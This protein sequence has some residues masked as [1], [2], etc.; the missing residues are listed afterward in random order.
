MMR[1]FVVAGEAISGGKEGSRWLLPLSYW[2]TYKY[3]H[4]VKYVSSMLH[5]THTLSLSISVFFFLLFIHFSRLRDGIIYPWG[6]QSSWLRGGKGNCLFKRGLHVET[7]GARV[8]LLSMCWDFI[9]IGNVVFLI[10]VLAA[11]CQQ[12]PAHPCT[13]TICLCSFINHRSSAC[14]WFSQL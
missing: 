5:D 2:Q 10:S 3:G 11:C 8:C 1:S 4:K 6:H 9:T 14:L 12:P 13:Q 7:L